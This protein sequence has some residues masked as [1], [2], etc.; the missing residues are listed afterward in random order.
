MLGARA[1]AG[2]NGGIDFDDELAARCAEVS[3]EFAGDRHLSTERD[4]ELPRVEHGPKARF[5]VGE[6]RAVLPSEELELGGGL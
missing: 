2:V 5:G 3:D 6:G 4:A 1:F